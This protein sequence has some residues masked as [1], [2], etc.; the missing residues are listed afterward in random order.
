MK[1]DVEGS[2][3]RVLEGATRVVSRSDR[4]V[5]LMDVNRKVIERQGGS[6]MQLSRVVRELG[7][8][9]MRVGKSSAHC[10]LLDDFSTKPLGFPDA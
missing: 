8:R 9:I 2:D 1:V 5:M 10:I 3:G 4:V 7:F 6:V